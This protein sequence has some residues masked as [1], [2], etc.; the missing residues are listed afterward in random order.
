MLNWRR[1][2]ALRFSDAVRGL[3][4]PN[5][6]PGDAGAAVSGGDVSFLRT[7]SPTAEEALLAA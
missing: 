4:C 1:W 7:Y 5:I 6:S 3:F 2:N